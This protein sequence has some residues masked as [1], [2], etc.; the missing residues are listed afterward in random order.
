MN[1]KELVNCTGADVSDFKQRV[2][3]I[4]LLDIWPDYQKLV[5]IFQVYLKIETI[6]KITFYKGNEQGVDFG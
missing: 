5:K 4:V 6:C 1:K 3:K 2:V